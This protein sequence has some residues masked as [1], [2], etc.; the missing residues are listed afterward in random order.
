MALL[1]HV[2]RQAN[3]VPVGNQVIL[4]WLAYPESRV[5]RA[6]LEKKARL[7]WLDLWEQLVYP[8]SRV[9]LDL[10]AIEAIAGY[11]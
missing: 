8:E 7:E 6:R 1:G 10:R 4:V 3:P 11:Q 5:N 9:F 2:D